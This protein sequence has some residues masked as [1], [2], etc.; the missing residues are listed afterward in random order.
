MWLIA[1]RESMASK[2]GR[3]MAADKTAILIL[4][5]LM[6]NEFIIWYKKTR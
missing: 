1:I 4:P 2:Y 6:M 5:T 3:I